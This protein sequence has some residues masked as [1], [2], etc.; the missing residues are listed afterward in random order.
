M[1]LDTVFIF[2]FANLFTDI[3]MYINITR[4]NSTTIRKIRI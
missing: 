4:T 2:I 3:I 1:F